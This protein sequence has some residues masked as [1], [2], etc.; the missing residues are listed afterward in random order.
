MTLLVFWEVSPTCSPTKCSC[1]TVVSWLCSV[2]PE[3]DFV[4]KYICLQLLFNFRYLYHHLYNTENIT[5]TFLNYLFTRCFDYITMKLCSFITFIQCK[6]IY[7]P[8]LLLLSNS[9]NN[10]INISNKNIINIVN[11]IIENNPLTFPKT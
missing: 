11:I 3:Q 2:S 7:S 9:V 4:V 5:L 10:Y 6:L 1:F 8:P